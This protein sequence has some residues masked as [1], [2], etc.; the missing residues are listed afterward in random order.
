MGAE[1]RILL[2]DEQADDRALAVVCLRQMFPAAPVAE[3]GGAVEFAEVLAGASYDLV[4]CELTLSW[5]SGTQV[6]A[7]VKRRNPHCLTFLFTNAPIEAITAAGLPLNLD[8]HLRKDSHGYLRLPQA[9]R[10]AMAVAAARRAHAPLDEELSNRARALERTNQ[11]LEQIA[12]AL[13]HDLQEPLQLI[14]RHARFLVDRYRSRLDNDAEKFL[15]HLVDSAA[16]MQTMIDG[17]LDY[18][19][20]GNLG[21][22]LQAVD[23]GDV[24]EEAVGNL[25]PVIAAAGGAVV[26][27]SLPAVNADRRQMVQLFHN[28]IGNAVKFRGSEPPRIEISAADR[29]ADWCIAVADNGIGIDPAD[30]QRI[31]GMFQR[32]HTR[33]EYPGTGVGLAICKRIVESHGGNITVESAAGRGT[34]FY[35]TFPKQAAM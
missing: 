7:A 18:S 15:H 25:Q 10:D 14:G 12:Y 32:L 35:V 17:V 30:T 26:K 29:G 16:R 13:S 33:E 21:L 31:F 24:V 20:I 27:R 23:L 22:Q 8:G 6:L 2:V 28:L 5:G 19:R 1:P 9:I 11:E 3:V 4:V 34:T